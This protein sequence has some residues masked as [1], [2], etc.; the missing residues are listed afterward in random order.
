MEDGKEKIRTHTRRR[1]LENEKK[2][3][4]KGILQG[5]DISKFIKSLQLRWH[6]HVKRMQN[7]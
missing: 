6:G 4:I 7:Q 2:Q 5:T 3:K 1:K